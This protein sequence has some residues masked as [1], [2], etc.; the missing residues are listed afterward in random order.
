MS[1]S[2]KLY[3]E[4]ELE[5]VHWNVKEDIECPKHEGPSLV[6]LEGDAPVYQ[7]LLALQ[8]AILEIKGSVI[9]YNDKGRLIVVYTVGSYRFVPI[10][11]V[12]ES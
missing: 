11:S 8:T 12:I 3:G 10:G 9:A 7:Y 2:I 6:I 5:V 4:F 1:E